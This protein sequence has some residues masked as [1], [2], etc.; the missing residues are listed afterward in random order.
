MSEELEMPKLKTRDVITAEA[1]R[2]FY[3]KGYEATSFADIA[4]AVRISRGNFYYHFRTKDEILKAVI[5]KRKSDRVKLLAAW[6]AQRSPKERIIAFIQIL[7][8]NQTKVMAFGCPIGTLATELAKLDHAARDDA[9]GLF[10]VFRT[11][12]KKQFLDLGFGPDSNDLAMHILMRSQG[13]ATLATALRDEAFVRREVE[14]MTVWL[15]AKIEHLGANS[16][17]NLIS[18]EDVSC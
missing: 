5:E 8:T 9:A 17:Q 4:E 7:I 13:V 2:L 14:D 12:L 10:D 6:E 16:E 3:E 15:D 11:W 1:D 18:M